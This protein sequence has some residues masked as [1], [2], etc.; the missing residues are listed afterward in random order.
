M[1]MGGNEDFMV[2]S[3]FGEIDLKEISDKVKSGL[4][5]VTIEKVEQAIPYLFEGVKVKK[6]VDKKKKK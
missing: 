2:M 3:V 1:V 5:I 6:S 4:N